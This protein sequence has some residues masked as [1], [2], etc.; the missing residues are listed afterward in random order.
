MSIQFEAPALS[1]SHRYLTAVLLHVR[2][3][4]N[5]SVA[6][7]LAKRERAALRFMKEPDD[8]ED[9]SDRSR[10]TSVRA[11]LFGLILAGSLSPAAAKP[12]DTIVQ[13]TIV[14]LQPD[15]R[16]FLQSLTAEE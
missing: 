5:R 8:Q 2:R 3:F 7:M 16:A 13:D 10:R 15:A 11:L 4:I 6:G 9:E 12:Q 14:Q 1:L